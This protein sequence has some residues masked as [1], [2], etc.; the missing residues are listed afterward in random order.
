M[1]RLPKPTAERLL[2]ELSGKELAELE[3]KLGPEALAKLANG[4]GGR[5]IQRFCDRLG[6][7][8]LKNLAQR[9]DGAVLEHYGVD[10]FEKYQGVTERT[11][12]H[13]LKNDG[14]VKGEIKGCHDEAMFLQ[15]LLGKQNGE[16]IRRTP[17]PTEPG[18]TKIEYRLYRRHPEGY[19]AMPPTLQSGKPEAKTVIR[20]LAEDPR[21]WQALANEALDG[22]IRRKEFPI[23]GSK[24]EVPTPGGL[25]IK[26]YIHDGIVDTFYVVW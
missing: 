8:K 21:K 12:E 4:L 1:G 17:H 19:V 23:A 16:I 5:E 22:A 24:F 13:L 26:G 15:A 10:F 2:G 7:A 25:K 11:M 9:F 6:G 20:G 18:V 14:I 3:S